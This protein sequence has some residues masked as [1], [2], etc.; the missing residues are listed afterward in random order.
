MLKSRLI[1]GR[2]GV[3]DDGVE[4]P[5]R[6]HL[7]VDERLLLAVKQDGD[8]VALVDIPHNAGAEI[9]VA[10]RQHAEADPVAQVQVKLVGLRNVEMLRTGPE[11]NQKNGRAWTLGGCVNQG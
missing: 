9:L 10:P 11:K 3:A 6:E 1:R 2:Y 8:G 7:V 4:L 5:P